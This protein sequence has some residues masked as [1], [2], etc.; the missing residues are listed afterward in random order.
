MKI[1]R[2]KTVIILED[3]IDTGN[4]LAEIYEIFR[5]KNVKTA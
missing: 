5:D 1:W 4:T 2:V 3:I